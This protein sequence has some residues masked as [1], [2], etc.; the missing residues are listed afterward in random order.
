MHA[1]PADTVL[2][3]L[4]RYLVPLL[5]K[6]HGLAAEQLVFSRDNLQ[7]VAQQY[8]REVRQD[9]PHIVATVS[10]LAARHC[11]SSGWLQP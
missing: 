3:L 11:P 2:A 4:Q 10:D 1:S 9:R 5:M 8:T 7:V 6:E